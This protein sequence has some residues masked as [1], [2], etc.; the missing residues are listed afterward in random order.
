MIHEISLK[1]IGTFRDGLTFSLEPTKYGGKMDN[2]CFDY[3]KTPILNSCIIY[4]KNSAGK[5]NLFKA[6][7][8]FV[9][10]IK[11]SNPN[12]ENLRAIYNPYKLDIFSRTAPSFF[13]ISFSTNNN[14]YKY[15]V[16]YDENTILHERLDV[17][18]EN[19]YVNLFIREYSS[20][21]SH[22]VDFTSRGAK[23][24]NKLP[25]VFKNQLV[26][27]LYLIYFDD[28]IGNVGRYLSNIQIVNGYNHVM[29]QHLWN[30]IQNWF[31][32][33]RKN[34]GVKLAKFLHAVDISVEGFSVPQGKDP[35][36]FERVSFSHLL[37]NGNEKTGKN[38]YISIL[39]ESEGTKW[40][41]LLG[42]KV[43]DSLEKGTPLFVDEFD[44]SFHAQVTQF[45]IDLYRNPNINKKGAQLILT[46]HNIN[47]MDES[48]L[49][50]DQIWFVDKNDYGFAEMYCLSDFAGIREDIP[51]A[52]WY[53]ANRLGALPNI[54]SI[55]DMFS[56]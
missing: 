25:K 17:F 37:Y 47:L 40:L 16:E 26:L 55:E 8:S 9:N 1:N 21:Q 23:G 10:F 33:D 38:V 45:I 20:E 46:T 2:F 5:T 22:N 27:S 52:D 36:S 42:A 29:K 13:H 54:G 49:R 18:E 50:S 15:Y 31:E 41:F 35:D 7:Y 4:G 30:D 32:K 19:D 34:N 28:E 39:D 43:L 48:K 44:S 6:L 14:K 56:E 51:F 53:L 12:F 24:A 3:D 11:K